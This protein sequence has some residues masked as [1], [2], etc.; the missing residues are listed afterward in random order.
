MDKP[1]TREIV[2]KMCSLI[3]IYAVRGYVT[4]INMPRLNPYVGF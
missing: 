3:M 1:H 4:Q 2:M